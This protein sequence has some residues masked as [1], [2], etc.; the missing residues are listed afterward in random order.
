MD[1]ERVFQNMRQGTLICNQVVALLWHHSKYEVDT[2]VFHLRW[3]WAVYH[4]GGPFL[5]DAIPAKLLGDGRT[6]YEHTSN[7]SVHAYIRIK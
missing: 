5:L 2:T 3:R 1:V 7:S 4:H 6:S